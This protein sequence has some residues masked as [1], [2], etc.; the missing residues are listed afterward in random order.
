LPLEQLAQQ[1]L[2]GLCVASALNKDI[3]HGPVLV[4]RAPEPVLYPRDRDHDLVHVPLVAG[5]GQPAADLIGEAL[6]EL[7]PLR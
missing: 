4:N 1:V 6:A 3:Q 2:G 5:G 7:A